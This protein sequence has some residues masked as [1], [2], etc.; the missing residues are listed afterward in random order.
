MTS[1]T[2]VKKQDPLWMKVL[3][4]AQKAENTKYAVVYH[5][6]SYI[7]V[8]THVHIDMYIYV[9]LNILLFYIQSDPLTY[10]TNE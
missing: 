2:T 9:S 10:Y 6:Y 5:M 7:C 3:M 8:N 4:I 1:D